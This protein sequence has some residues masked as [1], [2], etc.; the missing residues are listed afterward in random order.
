MHMLDD[1]LS[2]VY[3]GATF[4]LQV[5]I[6]RAIPS[7]RSVRKSVSGRRPLGGALFF[8]SVAARTIR[9]RSTV[10]KNSVKKHVTADT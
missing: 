9:T 5:C 7:P 10:P 8:L 6:P 1:M 2:Q 3:L 4:C